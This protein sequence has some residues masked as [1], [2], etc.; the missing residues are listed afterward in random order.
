MKENLTEKNEE[1]C[2]KFLNFKNTNIEIKV[3][4]E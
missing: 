3:Q 1:I 2:V 4:A